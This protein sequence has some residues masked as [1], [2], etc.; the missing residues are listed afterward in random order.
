MTKKK[1]TYGNESIDILEGADR[2]RK[3]PSVIFGSDGLDGCEHA[4][5]EI[6]IQFTY[7]IIKAHIIHFKSNISSS[8]IFR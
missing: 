5:F 4:V 1:P 2:V 8:F 6:Y 3:K 7:Y